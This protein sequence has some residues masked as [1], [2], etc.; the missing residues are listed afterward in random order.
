MKKTILLLITL[1]ALIVMALSTATI[2][3]AEE[4]EEPTIEQT[5]EQA[6]IVEITAKNEAWEWC[7][8]VY[9]KGKSAI[10]GAV[11][12][13]SGSAIIGAIAIVLVKRATNK[14]LDKVEKTGDASTIA[15]LTTDAMLEKINCLRTKAKLIPIKI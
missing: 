9:A 4:T 15:S 5:T 10:L 13:V 2:C 8:K 1:F 6:V 11:G 14:T 7:K 12:G 3:Y